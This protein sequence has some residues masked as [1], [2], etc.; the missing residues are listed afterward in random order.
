MTVHIYKSNNPG[1]K[2]P[3]RSTALDQGGSTA[4]VEMPTMLSTEHAAMLLKIVPNTMRS[5]HCK[6]GNYMG[7]KPI[8][9]PNRRLLWDAKAIAS[10]LN[11]GEVK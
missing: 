3:D 6:T 1:P 9:L 11:N 5:S 2:R 10:L 7:I 4:T 8:K